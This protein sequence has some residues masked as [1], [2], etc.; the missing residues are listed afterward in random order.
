MTAFDTFASRLAPSGLNLVGSISVAEWDRVAPPSRQSPALAPG[1]RSIVVVGNG[2]RAMWDGMLHEIEQDPRRLV[3]EPHPVDA[4]ARRHVSAAAEALGEPASPWFYAAADATVHLDFRE[5]ARM[6]GFGSVGR[7]GLI[8]HPEYGP[9]LGLRAATFVQAEYSPT[10][11]AGPHACDGCAAPCLSACPGGAFV[12]GEWAVDKCSTFKQ[13]STVC[14]STCHSRS[15]CPAGAAHRY[16]EE[17]ITYH[18]NRALGR[19]A[20][21]ERFGI[22]AD[23]FDGVGPHWSDWR[24]RVNME[25]P[26]GER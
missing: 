3:D 14:A 11:V 18:A 22:K 1:A 26:G 4:Y 13:N 10:P 20:L 21:R 16:P 5:L 8:M 7:L 25:E 9:W 19:A 23:R 24:A 17:L 2:G 12:S 15:A 6:A